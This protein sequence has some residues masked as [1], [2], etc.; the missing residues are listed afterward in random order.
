MSYIYKYIKS[1]DPS[2]P[3]FFDGMS[4]ANNN[5]FNGKGQP[6]SFDAIDVDGMTQ[7]FGFFENSYIRPFPEFVGNFKLVYAYR[8][9]YHVKG[10]DTIP[11]EIDLTDNVYGFDINSTDITTATFK[12]RSKQVTE[13]GTYELCCPATLDTILSFVNCFYRPVMYTIH[14]VFSNYNKTQIQSQYV[15][16]DGN[17]IIACDSTD[18]MKIGTIEN[19]ITNS[20]H[21]SVGYADPV[22]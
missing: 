22:L 5:Q 15:K 16:W 21:A 20:L 3:K 2:K 13:A 4:L 8:M 17:T 18:P 9:F 1:V 12:A 7:F 14:L 6:Y 11:F 10:F 19:F